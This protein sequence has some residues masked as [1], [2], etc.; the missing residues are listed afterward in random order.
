MVEPAGS[1][2]AVEHDCGDLL[3]LAFLKEVCGI[4]ERG[5]RLSARSG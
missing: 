3:G 5:V 2:H 1:S 4:L